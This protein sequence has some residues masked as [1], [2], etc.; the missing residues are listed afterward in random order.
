MVGVPGLPYLKRESQCRKM[1]DEFMLLKHY[2][3]S[4]IPLPLG[5]EAQHLKSGLGDIYFLT[6]HLN[7]T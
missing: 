1:H 7:L 6:I 3:V 2:L 5:G 4:L